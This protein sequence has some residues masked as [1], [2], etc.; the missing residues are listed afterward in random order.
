MEILNI[1]IGTAV[2]FA[3]G[4]AVKGQKSKS[5]ISSSSGKPYSVLYDETIQELSK[6]KTELRSRESEIEDLNQRIRSLSRKIRNDEDE[7][8]DRADDF[9]DMRRTI[10]SLRKENIVLQDKMN[11]YKALYES[12][13]QEI[14]RLNA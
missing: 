4:Y 3:G 2:G 5:E 10:E 8:M 7:T 12:A 11:D 14:D 1:L 9:A 6:A 13:K